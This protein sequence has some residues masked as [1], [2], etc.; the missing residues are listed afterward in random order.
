MRYITLLA[1]LILTSC[2]K[3]VEPVLESVHPYLRPYYN[4]FKELTGHVN[5]SEVIV[6]EFSRLMPQGVLGVA[7]GMNAEGT[8]L[9][10]INANYWSKLTDNQKWYLVMHE[11]AHDILNL[12]HGDIILMETPMPR[13]VSELMIN[14]AK[15]DLNDYS[16]R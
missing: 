10:K 3:E 7:V 14:I 16:R 9:V 15:A 13:Y 5:T 4:E 8:I 11:L 1:L 12:E 6:M 2:T